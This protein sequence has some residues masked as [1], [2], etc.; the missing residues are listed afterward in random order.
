MGKSL[1][2]AGCL[3][4]ITD[5]G[6][7]DVSGLLSICFAAYCKGTTIHHCALRIRKCGEPMEIGGITVRP[8]D[9]MHA[10]SEGVIR[11]PSSCLEALPT[12]ATQMRAFESAAHC[13]LR[14]TDIKASDK[15]RR[16]GELLAEYGF[17]K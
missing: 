6:V 9:I 10:N 3:G 17:G 14:Q 12:R 13:V 11:I 7:R 4:V 15:R 2:A 16:V 8:G 5:G 1:F